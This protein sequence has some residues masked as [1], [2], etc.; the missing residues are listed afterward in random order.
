MQPCI[1]IPALVGFFFMFW[2]EKY[3]LLHRSRRPLTLMKDLTDNI[4]LL[5]YL[6]PMILAWGGFFWVCVFMNYF[7]SLA[8]AAYL[9]LAFLSFL[10]FITPFTSFYRCLWHIPKE[11]YLFYNDCRAQLPQ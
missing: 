5:I 1:I 4:E 10:Y 6:G 9:T 2:V 8:L 11:D 7:N 3:C